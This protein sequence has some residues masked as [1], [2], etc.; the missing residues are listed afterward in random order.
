MT[1][2]LFPLATFSPAI[3]V[4]ANLGL[5]MDALADMAGIPHGLLA[6][7][8]AL[9]TGRQYHELAALGGRLLHDPAFALN[10]SEWIRL[11]M[12]EVLGPLFS[13]TATIRS[14]VQDTVRFMPLI[15]PCIDVSLAE[16]GDEAHYFCH[17]VP[18]QGAD[19]R[20]FHA[21]ACFA[22]G[23]RMM[24]S[25][26]GRPG[27]PDLPLLRIEVQHDGSGW[28]DAWRRHFG[29]RTEFV[30]NAPANVAV[31]RREWLDRDNRGHSPAIHALMQ[32]AALARLAELPN[33]ETAS[34]AVLRLLEQETGTRILDLGEVAAKLGMTTRT[35]QRRLVEEHTTF[36]QL[37]DGLRLRQAQALLR[38]GTQDIATIAATL[39]FS[40]PAT[41]H[42]AFKAW[43]GLSPAEYRRRHNI[44][45]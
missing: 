26:F 6:D 4:V 43:A 9:I 7:P 39:G 22:G 15:D 21:E 1:D 30:F 34:T 25:V 19:S 45:S 20:F 13:T 16:E 24:R 37:R 35:L 5:N 36:Q 28:L 29:D 27:E 8:K 3:S 33:V 12:F 10:V 32:K 38:D 18:G 42:R 2:R 40:E 14:Y 44:E 31:F 41:F 11:D 23:Y 17:L